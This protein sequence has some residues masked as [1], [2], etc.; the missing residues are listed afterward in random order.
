MHAWH[1]HVLGQQAFNASCRD[2][3]DVSHDVMLMCTAALQVVFMKNM[4][5]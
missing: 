4:F 1:V 2:H 3:D 5:K